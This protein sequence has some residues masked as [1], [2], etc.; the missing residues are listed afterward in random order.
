MV[1]WARRR[2]LIS[3]GYAAKRCCLSVDQHTTN[4]P[5]LFQTHRSSCLSTRL[6]VS[7]CRTWCYPAVGA[8]AAHQQSGVKNSR[9]KISNQWIPEGLQCRSL[10]LAPTTAHVIRGQQ[11]QR[12]SRN[13]A[14][15]R[16]SADLAHIRGCWAAAG[17]MPPAGSLRRLPS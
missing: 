7:S 9:G 17:P 3:G 6:L 13:T 16:R 1:L 12:W 8:K 2:Y 4:P 11:Q 10:K 5:L 14:R 15:P